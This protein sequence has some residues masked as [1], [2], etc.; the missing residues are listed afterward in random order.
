MVLRELRNNTEWNYQPVGFVDDDPAK[1]D[2]VINGLRVYDANGSL[3]N[4]CREKSVQEILISFRVISAE[5]L[6]KVRETCREL[7]VDL[8]RAQIKIEPMD[9]E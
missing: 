4:I 9:F 1:K 7:N 5:K 3:D 8:K 2:K 6:Q